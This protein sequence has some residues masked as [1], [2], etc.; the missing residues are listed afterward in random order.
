MDAFCHFWRVIGHM[1]GIRDEFNICTD[2]ARTTL[3]RVLE[4]RNKI[5]VQTLLKPCKNFTK[6]SFAVVD[7]L[8]CFNPFLDYD[9]VMY[10]TS[11]LAHVPGYTYSLFSF[12]FFSVPKNL[13]K[14]SLLGRIGLWLM[15]FTHTIQLQWWIPRVYHN[16]QILVSEFLIRYFPFLAFYKFG[17]IKKSYIRI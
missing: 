17:S 15:V 16:N 11:M 2:D 9:A 13:A 8:W 6:M 10:F 12:D 4:I 1:L 7:G 3:P 14:I 5:Y